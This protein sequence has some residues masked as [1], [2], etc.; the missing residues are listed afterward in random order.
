MIQDSPKYLAN[1]SFSDE[2]LERAKIICLRNHDKN[3]SDGLEFPLELIVKHRNAIIDA[4]RENIVRVAKTYLIGDEIF[5]STTILGNETQ[6]PQFKQSDE[7]HF[8]DK[9]GDYFII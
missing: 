9:S 2:E 4:K 3:L 5:R 8:I 1:D 6:I 7:W